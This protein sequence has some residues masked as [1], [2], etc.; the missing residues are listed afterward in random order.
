[1][2]VPMN[3]EGSWQSVQEAVSA[4]RTKARQIA[5]PTRAE[6]QALLGGDGNEARLEAL[7]RGWS[8]KK[9][10]K[11]VVVLIGAGV[12][13]GA[14]FPDFRDKESGVYARIQKQHGMAKPENIFRIDEYDRNPG[15]LGLWLQEFLS[16]RDTASPTAAHL[17]LSLLEE[18][19]LLL[20][21]YSQNI[22]GLELKAGLPGHRIVSAH[23]DM[24]RPSCARCCARY[25]L[26]EFERGI[27]AG[28]IP[29]C[30]QVG[31]GGP[32]RPGIVFFSEP[33]CI[34][35]DYQKDFDA[36]DLLIIMGT[37]LNVH[38][39]ASLAARVPVLCPRLL[40]NRDKVLIK[41]CQHPS[42]QLNFD[43]PK[44]YRDVWLGGECDESTRY[45]SSQLGWHSDLLS[46][47]AK[48][49]TVDQVDDIFRRRA[50]TKSSGTTAVSRVSTISRAE[51]TSD[52]LCMGS[53][54]AS[55]TRS[56]ISDLDDSDLLLDAGCIEHPY[57]S[58][59]SSLLSPSG[60]PLS[61]SNA[62]IA[63]MV[64]ELSSD[65]FHGELDLVDQDTGHLVRL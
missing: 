56:C 29:R 30:Q 55:S 42:R 24:M 53:G 63:T 25:P 9:F 7:L 12:S 27:K 35:H 8:D 16:V 61:A 58:T 31:C 34:P 38:P 2:K 33:P 26:N 37:S 40:V 46:L 44:A 1:M 11:S 60:V 50:E 48:H 47:E 4:M 62:S 14:G 57:A 28:G 65:G 32:V 43:G 41:N 21:C 6:R 20:R 51:S 13:V 45:I 52:S 59:P 5:G 19:G 36:C 23:G 54:F 10:G 64:T 3:R 17:F 18:K 39:F 49:Q 15:P 22:D